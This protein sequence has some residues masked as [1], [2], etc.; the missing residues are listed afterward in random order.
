MRFVGAGAIALTFFGLRVAVEVHPLSVFALNLVTGL[1][2]GLAIDYSLFIVSRW[3]EE[4][5]RRRE[6]LLRLGQVLAGP[7]RG[8]RAV[9]H[10]EALEHARQVGL[11]GPLG[12]PETA[13]LNELPSAGFTTLALLAAMAMLA[14]APAAHADAAPTPG[15]GATDPRNHAAAFEMIKM[16]GGVF[17]A[18]VDF[19]D[20]SRDPGADRKSVV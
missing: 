2:L 19:D 12:D 8:L 13:G 4:A 20:L 11:H 17:G 1:G 14:A 3:R 15:T 16:Q 9:G 18:A 10:A 5:A 6:R 7:E